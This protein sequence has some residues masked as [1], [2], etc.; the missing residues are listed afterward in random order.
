MKT[1][2][3]FSTIHQSTRAL[4][5][6]LP[7]LGDEA[8]GPMTCQGPKRSKRSTKIFGD[9][10]KPWYP[11]WTPSHSWDLWMFIP[12]KMVFIGID[13]YPFDVICRFSTP[14]SAKVCLVAVFV[15]QQVE[16][17]FPIS[18][19]EHLQNRIAPKEPSDLGTLPVA[20][21]QC[22][23]LWSGSH[24]IAWPSLD[25]TATLLWTQGEQAPCD[26][27][28]VPKFEILAIFWLRGCGPVHIC[29]L[30]TIQPPAAASVEGVAT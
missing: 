6:A 23:C 10:S 2:V 5:M 30:S 15:P 16:V 7:G 3:F 24:F 26:H 18:S 8:G 1:A 29:T 13:P 4:K 28:L 21:M 14:W 22:R 11:W 25:P 12:L 20:S 27:D 19:D 17:L 9:G